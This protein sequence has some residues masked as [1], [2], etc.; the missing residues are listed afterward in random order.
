[1]ANTVLFEADGPVAIIT[2]NRPDNGNRLTIETVGE[3][4]AAWQNLG[5]D[6]RLRT[7]VLTGA[8]A[9]FCEGEEGG[10]SPLSLDPTAY[11][12]WKP[13]VVA[14][15]G[16]CAG[17]GLRFVG[18]GDIVIAA[19]NA[20]FAGAPLSEGIPDEDLVLQRRRLPM[21]MAELL[22][23][24]GGGWTIDAQRAYETGWVTELTEPGALLN[25][26]KELAQAVA[27]NDP[28]AV[29]QAKEVLVKGRDVFTRNAVE[30]GRGLVV[31][32]EKNRTAREAILARTSK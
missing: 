2:L 26:A 25:R 12:V 20:V 7:A 18:T 8:G 31:P 32:L 6:S 27:A 23:M 22:I 15:N 3:L 14:V 21:P 11:G 4:V 24:S 29:R 17:A 13:V 1:M 30:Q 9:S 19:N 28:E 5:S 10:R 16:R